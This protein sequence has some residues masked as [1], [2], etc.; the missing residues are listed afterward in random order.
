MVS[1]VALS[2]VLLDRRRPADSQLRAPAGRRARLRLRRLLTFRLSLPESRY[3]TF[4]KG[5]SFFDELFAGLRR[6]PGVRGVAAHQ[7]AAVQR[8]RRQPLVPHRGARGEAAGGSDRGAVANRH[9]R[10]LRGD[11]HPDR[12]RAGIHRSRCAEPA[13]ASRSS[14]TR[15]RESTCHTKARSASACRSASDEPHWYEIV[16]VAGNIKHRGLDARRS[17]R[18][19]TCRIDSRCSRAGRC[20]RCTSSCERPAIRSSPRRSSGMRSRGSIA[21]SRSPTCGRW[22][23]A[24]AARCRRR[25]FNMVLLALFAGWR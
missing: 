2:L 6:S 23:S 15:W 17:A 14:T 10:L 4:E 7:R 25:R 5:Q 18:S 24:S 9:R 11:G 13:R 20:G 8:R 12:R 21:I 1:E 3:T 19:C 16:G 22:T